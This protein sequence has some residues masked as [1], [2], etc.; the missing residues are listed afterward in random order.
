M[1]TVNSS[2]RIVPSVT[3][4]KY[5]TQ[6][7]LPDFL[8]ILFIYTYTSTNI[9]LN[10]SLLIASRLNAF[11]SHQKASEVQA[12]GM[13][14]QKVSRAASKKL[15]IQRSV[16]TTLFCQGVEEDPNCHPVTKA[17]ACHAGL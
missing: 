14:F 15:Q 6:A 10:A 11:G 1:S 7:C 8:T 12:L 9:W 4:A 16:P 17:Q 13:P 3:P 2:S 5:D